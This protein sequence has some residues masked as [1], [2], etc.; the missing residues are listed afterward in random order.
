M[1]SYRELYDKFSYTILTQIQHQVFL[2]TYL[3]VLQIRFGSSLGAYFYQTPNI[4]LSAQPSYFNKDLSQTI[5]T[6]GIEINESFEEVIQFSMDRARML[7]SHHSATIQDY[8]GGEI[9][10]G[11]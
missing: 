1:H 2:Q 8:P 11:T 10:D 5:Q 7:N 9:T 6:L 4:T 3:D